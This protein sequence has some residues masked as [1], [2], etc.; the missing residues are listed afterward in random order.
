VWWVRFDQKSRE[1]EKGGK[2]EDIN[3]EQVLENVA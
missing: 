2:G 3:E 1:K